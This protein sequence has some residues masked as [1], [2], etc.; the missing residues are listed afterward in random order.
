MVVNSLRTVLKKI[1]K[2]INWGLVSLSMFYKNMS[3]RIKLMVI[4]N[5][6]ILIPLVI[7]SFV[8]YKN[9]E[10]VLKN[11]SIQYSQDILKII[12]LRVDDYISD[13]NS[14]TRDILDDSTISHY[15]QHDK[16]ETDAVKVYHDKEEVRNILK[17]K[18]R[19][20]G[21]MQSISIFVGDL[22]CYADDSTQ[23]ES[24]EKMVPY[25]SVPYKQMRSLAYRNEGTPIWYFD[26]S[27]EQ[28][29][30]FYARSI[31]DRNTYKNSGILVIMVNT[32]WF[33]TVFSGLVNDDMKK[34]A[35]M[36][37]DKQ[38]VLSQA[39]AET[40]QLSD[41][42]FDEMSYDHGWIA[43]K[44]QN[45]LISY[46]TVA[47][48]GW[49]IASYI[50]LSVLFRDVEYLKHKIILAL[51]CAVVFLLLVS[52]YISF[53]FVAAINKIV[54]GMTRLK[55]GEENVSVQLMRK[56]ELGF[57]GDT[58]N[59]MV[60]EITT[61]Q[62]WV[63]R[64]QLTRKDSQIKALQSQINPH[65]L[66]NTLETINWMAQ[67]NH[68]PE[69]SETVTAL[70]SLMEASMARTGK[71]I[72]LEE[73]FKYIDNYILI[74]KKRFE[75]RLELVKEIDNRV[76]GVKVPRLLIQPLIENAA[77][78]GV[79]NIRTKGIVHLTAVKSGE[80]VNITVEDN[81]IGI[82]PDELE[83]I[84]ERLSMNDDEY[85]KEEEGRRR[86]GIGLENVNR[87]IKLFYGQQYG[88]RIESKEGCYTRVYVDIPLEAN[89]RTH[90]DLD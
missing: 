80:F 29:H 7:I 56:D 74:L 64:E 73:E 32:D 3:I 40:Y 34:T 87:R 24:I 35:I 57:M 28:P 36:S 68:A 78:H 61:L 49:K 23:S 38:V 75:D 52:F 69:I 86:H 45:T 71:C 16:T 76:L 60:K 50:P 51:I 43:D 12:N 1:R 21:E 31:I 19:S 27:G 81:G 72:T 85:F 8:S 25:N 10:D 22:H 15:I 84:N 79:A 70:A 48:T 88:L 82:D 42:L 33:K 59:T 44:A 11:K 90:D 5:I 46:V 4:L 2:Y 13:L 77:N 58:F 54:D 14:M 17:D 18:I 37:K 41:E 63:L 53:D 9:S 65:F 55:E 20:K 89:D 83:M 26:N 66:F 39:G 6:V 30:I 62:K 47:D 67:L